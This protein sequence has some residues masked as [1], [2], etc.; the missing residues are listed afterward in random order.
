MH[1]ILNATRECLTEH[2][3]IFISSA[4]TN[5]LNAIQYLPN[6]T[7]YLLNA[8]QYLPNA[9]TYLLQ[10]ILA[11][12]HTITITLNKTRDFS[13]NFFLVQKY[14]DISYYIEHKRIDSFL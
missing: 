14:L 10:V 12:D 2:I 8:I 6:A 1:N 13:F 3:T 11:K 7:T 5:L 4:T 9:T